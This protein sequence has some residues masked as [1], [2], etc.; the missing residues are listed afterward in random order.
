MSIQIKSDV[1]C[2]PTNYKAGRSCPVR[3][4]VIHYVG[5]EGGARA[6]AQ[7]FHN[8]AHVQSSAHYFV[9]HA[10]E[11][12]VIYASV[13]EKD[14]AWHCGAKTYS[15]P[16]CRNANSIGVELCCHRDASSR[17][18]FDPATVDAAVELTRMLMEKYHVRPDHVVRHYDV[19][20]KLCPA[21]FVN[22]PAAWEAFRRRLG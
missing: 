22:D 2:N 18:Y 5:A 21:P 12:A 19:T 16:E 6:N 17:W 14:V 4:L 7:Y 20:G 9:G 1:P 13:A 11:A 15:H 8:T 10:S 3:Y